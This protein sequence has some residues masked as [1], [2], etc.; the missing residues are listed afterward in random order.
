MAGD[1][2]RIT[3]KPA[4]N[5]A[6][7]LMQQGRVQL[8][9]DWNELVDIVGR[10]WRAETAD[11]MGRFAVPRQNPDG[12]KIAIDAAGNLTVARGRIYVDGLL[13]ENHGSGRIQ[14][15]P[16]WGEEVGIDPVTY[17]QQ[18]Y[19]R[20]PIPGAPPAAGGPHLV[21]L[22]VFERELTAVEDSSLVE[23]AVGVDTVV[24]R[25][26]AWAVKILPD[27]GAGVTCGSDWAKIQKWTDLIQPSAGRLTTSPTGVVKPSDP[28]AVSASGGFRGLENR[29]Y[30]VEI[31]DDG[32]HGTPASFKWSRDD[33]SV[34]AV[35]TQID[36]PA[37]PQPQVHV[38][39]LGRDLVTRFKQDDWV[40][41][42]DDVIELSGAPGVMARVL[43]V[44]AATNSVFLSAALAGA[45]DTSRNARIRR[46]DQV[47]DVNAIG[48]IPVTVAA[49]QYELEDGV[50]IT[51]TLDPATGQY[52]AGD[53]WT[54]TARVIDSS[55]E[56]LTSAPPRGIRHH[57]CRLAILNVGQQPEDCRVLWP[58]EVVGG[59][60]DCTECVSPDSHRSG[61][62]TLQ[63][64]IDNVKKTGG[65]VC[66]EP[67]IYL[68]EKPLEIAA[69]VSVTLSGH[70]PSTILVHG[71]SGPA[72][73]IF[74]STAVT[75]EN[76]TIVA[77]GGVDSPT[78]AVL[79]RNCLDITIQRCIL[80]EGLRSLYALSA[81]IG[82]R[83]AAAPVAVAQVS[84][85]NGAAIALSGIVAGMTVRE[86]LLVG[87]CGIVS[88]EALVSQ[89][90]SITTGFGKPTRDA[91]GRLNSNALGPDLKGYLLAGEIGIDTNL[92]VCRMAGVVL[93]PVGSTTDFL[94]SGR[95]V[96]IGLG[97]LSV[98]ENSFYWCELAGV[99]I[100]LAL[101]QSS[102]GN[103]PPARLDIVSNLLA[104]RGYGILVASDKARV[105]YNDILA[106]PGANQSTTIAGIYI[107]VGM[108]E[109]GLDQCQILANRID[110]IAGAGILVAG[111]I[112][113][114]LIKDNMISNVGVVGIGMT[115]EASAD[116]LSIENNQLLN[117]A[118]TVNTQDKSGRAVGI[119]VH[120]VAAASI[121]ANQVRGLGAMAA[122]NPIR[123]G[124]YA[125]SCAELRISG[126]QVN[127]LGPTGDALGTTYGIGIQDPGAH[128][129]VSDNTV[130]PPY[131]I[132]S[133]IEPRVWSALAV[134]SSS[135]VAVGT[136]D[137]RARTVLETIATMADFK[138]VRLR[139]ADGSLVVVG[140]AVLALPS[141][142]P[143]LQ[144][145]G[146]ILESFGRDPAC[147]LSCANYTAQFANNHC[148][149]VGSGDAVVRV[150]VPDG[151]AIV[152][153]NRVQG[154]TQRV[155]M[156]IQVSATPTPASTIVGNIFD[157]VVNVNG[158]RLTTT[159]WAA[160]NI[161]G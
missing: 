150:E 23:K 68:L 64:A 26:V 102:S 58:P 136:T 153:A 159:P 47:R 80:A 125:S 127:N 161:G 41:L 118:P 12:F 145:Q 46:W 130:A 154:S 48:V 21:Y 79:V 67:G 89:S 148:R 138:T 55:V 38:N 87:D 37:G 49:G 36:T 160:L 15:E 124:I 7:V 2:S 141:Q 140:P 155:S 85:L 70:G 96:E 1:Y 11:I 6:G 119:L 54:F 81:T 82:L 72:V 61:V 112:A 126:N 66:L 10:R 107:G 27:V 31:H 139:R 30:R 120:M 116:T 105:A 75:L 113:S 34:A 59:G 71:G 69:A 142:L 9:A 43:R 158:N 98:R 4:N 135:P 123:A 100:G 129:D 90:S 76:L 146:N 3:F 42:M 111:R 25:Q 17:A 134:V 32:T 88:A 104:V 95:D 65:K 24:R 13:A 108:A 5:S 144:V 74:A 77:A 137:V 20:P 50:S 78:A 57:Y 51:L 8:D 33:G 86:N 60:C 133:Y 110:G 121:S 52:H 28:C 39:R 62:L 18:P 73:D 83:A 19:F 29:L 44:D 152:S 56:P 97:N 114:G 157:G 92:F 131:E 122:Q 53:Y 91:V 147:R 45:I 149:N 115:P 143:T 84:L 14:V 22:D 117:I 93:G 16:V 40:E 132:Y 103:A 156:E 101:L 63:Q 109:S 94:R 35:V 128:V 106:V 151:V 99:A